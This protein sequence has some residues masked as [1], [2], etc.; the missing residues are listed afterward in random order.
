[1]GAKGEP[2]GAQRRWKPLPSKGKNGRGKRTQNPLKRREIK[3]DV[4]Q[5]KSSC[6][7]GLT[8][9]RWEEIP[10]ENSTVGGRGQS[11]T[12]LKRGG[13]L[14]HLCAEKPRRSCGTS[15]TKDGVSPSKQR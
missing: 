15:Y 3:M 5:Y 12:I 9:K 14:V 4:G 6:P 13:K 10:K 8:K 1:V 2:T 7:E 11:T